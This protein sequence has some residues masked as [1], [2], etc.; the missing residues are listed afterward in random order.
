MRRRGRNSQ[1]DVAQALDAVSLAQQVADL[2]AERQG[3][4][5]DSTDGGVVG[6]LPGAVTW[7]S[8]ARGIRL[9]PVQVLRSLYVLRHAKSSWDDPGL[10][11]HARPLF[12]PRGTGQPGIWPPT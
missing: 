1:G 5:V 3:L 10:G 11:D 12:A 2:A 6:P 7:P 9:C 8:A 4:L